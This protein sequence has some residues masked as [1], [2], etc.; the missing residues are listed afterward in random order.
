M[1]VRR[2]VTRLEQEVLNGSPRRRHVAPSQPLE[3]VHSAERRPSVSSGRN[4]RPESF[5]LVSGYRIVGTLI[6]T[7]RTVGLSDHS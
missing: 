5:E 6:L 2:Q 1:Q 4:P 7:H 3:H